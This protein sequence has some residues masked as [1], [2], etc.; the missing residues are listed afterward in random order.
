MMRRVFLCGLLCVLWAPKAMA[1]PRVLL[2]GVTDYPPAVTERAGVLNGPGADVALMAEVFAAAGVAPPDMTILSDRP[3][4]LPGP[5]Q[6]APPTRAAILGALEALARTAAS[7][8]R[9]IVYL[10]GHGAQVPAGAASDEPDGL[11]EVFLPSD[12]SI[13]ADGTHRNLIRDDEIGQ[14]IDTIIA[15]GADV[16][17][18][19]DSC[20]SGSL[21][22]SAGP[23]ATA[24]F[25]NLAS[26]GASA[27][28]LVDMAAPQ[29]ARAGQFVGFYA[30]A[31]GALAYETQPAGA[32]TTH[33]L[34]TWTLAKALRTGG[35]QTYADLARILSA[36]L[37]QIGRGLAEP[38]VAGATGA[39]HMFADPARQSGVHA[40]GFGGRVVV[41]AGRL[42]GL[43]P[44]SRIQIE[45]KA[46]AAL[47]TV[48]LQQASLTRATAPMPTGPIPALDARLRD[49]GLDPATF[50][51]RWLEDRAPGLVARVVATPLDIALPVALSAETLPPGLRGQLDALIAGL[52]PA[53]RRDDRNPELQIVAD[54]DEI[55]LRPAPEGAVAAL[56]VPASASA[57]PELAVLLRRAAKSRGLLAAA[58]ALRGS[59]L[60][61]AL[62]LE[63]TVTA[64]RSNAQGGCVADGAARALDLA[65][66][67]PPTIFHCQGVTLTLHNRN[68]WPVD[69]S[70][71]YIAADHQVYFLTG[72][73]GAERGGWR[74]PAQGQSSLR[75]TEATR[76]TTAPQIAT[77]PMHLVLFA[78]PGRIGRAPVDFR[79]LQDITPPPNTRA[80]PI[81]GLA[82]VL[83]AAGFGLANRRSVDET[84][85]A[86]GGALILPLKTVPDEKVGWVEQSL[87]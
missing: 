82:S 18:I 40:V 3:D 5:F 6:A 56:R 79:Y 39:P 37:W 17:L 47:F 62:S 8:D 78:Q 55:F 58:N 44:G 36:Q 28:P 77:G 38:E 63:A 70:P 72:Y 52:A 73:D 27:E 12:F 87:E 24:R 46:G 61:H 86:A 84:E 49:E 14:H 19:A 65:A 51:A 9:I 75:Y 74:I 81:K 85:T 59:A 45:D 57:L 43:L 30:A 68:P 66:P 4:L 42:D 35:A 32:G 1:D 22:R 53:V 64:G 13:L 80:G 21:R 16:W 71:F 15:A 50:R 25:V 60:A 10:A 48:G 69:V 34:L 2:V 33:G 31:A 20:H 7:G 67:Q 23:N 41:R 83:T 76:R 11:A 26:R 29:S 54:T